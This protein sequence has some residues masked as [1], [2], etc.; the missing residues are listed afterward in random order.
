MARA[1]RTIMYYDGGCPL[2]RRE[3]DHY[4]RLDKTHRVRWQDIAQH[5][6]ELERHGIRAQDALARLHV[7]DRNG[8]LQTGAWAFAAVWDELPGY[9]W[10]ARLVRALHLIPAMDMIYRRFAPWRLRRR[11]RDDRC[12]R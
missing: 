8:D 1:H 11:C 7:I 5:V 2:C 12:A 10:L 6:S 4:R 3:V 9:R